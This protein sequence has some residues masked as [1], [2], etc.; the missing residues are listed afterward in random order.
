MLF[1]FFH[2]EGV[3]AAAAIIGFA[4]AIV[5]WLYHGANAFQANARFVQDMGTNHLPHIYDRLGQID[6][7]LGIEPK[8]PPSIRFSGD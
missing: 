8:Q 4:W 5:R 7:R 3:A 2:A 6:Y 1:H